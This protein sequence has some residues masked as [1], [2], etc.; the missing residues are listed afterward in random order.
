[1][2]ICR[3]VGQLEKQSPSLEAGV[4]KSQHDLDNTAKREAEI[5]EEVSMSWM[6]IV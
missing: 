6:I 4:E 3:E 2:V 5:A 1:M